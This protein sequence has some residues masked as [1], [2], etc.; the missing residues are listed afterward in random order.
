MKQKLLPILI[1][2]DF[3]SENEDCLWVQMKE[4]RRELIQRYI[5]VTHPNTKISF[6]SA[7][8]RR[9]LCQLK[10]EKKRTTQNERITVGANAKEIIASQST[11]IEGE[12]RD[13]SSAEK[14]SQTTGHRPS[15]S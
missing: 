3:V 2:T 1:A 4:H 6:S 11:S 10:V 8:I 12:T 13:Y 7:E 9:D 15:S 5:L 14:V